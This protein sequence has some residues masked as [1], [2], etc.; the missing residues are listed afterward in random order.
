MSGTTVSRSGVD[1]LVVEFPGNR[2]SDRAAEQLRELAARDFVRV[3]DLAFVTRDEEGVVRRTELSELDPE[4]RRD[5]EAVVHSL[6]GLIGSE[7]VMAAAADLEPGHTACVML[8]ENVWA[9]FLGDAVR[10]SGGRV[11]RSTRVPA[12]APPASA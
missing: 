11:L 2:I 9:G 6:E 3:V 12:Q 4:A 10:R 8:V 7:D 5:Y 1:R